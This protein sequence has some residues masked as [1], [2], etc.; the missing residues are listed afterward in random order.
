MADLSLSAGAIHARIEVVAGNTTSR[1]DSVNSGYNRA[2]GGIDPRDPSGEAHVWGFLRPLSTSDALWA[3]TTTEAVAIDATATANLTTTANTFYPSMDQKTIASVTL[4]NEYTMTYVS[5]TSITM[6]ANWTD[7]T[8]DTF[9]IT[10]DGIYPLDDD[11]GGFVDGPVYAYNSS[12]S[13]GP[14]VEADMTEIE[15][16][17]RDDNE[18]GL[19][20]KWAVQPRS[21]TTTGQKYDLVVH[22]VPDSTRAIRYR[23]EVRPTA[24][25]DSTSVYALGT[26]KFHHAIEYAALADWEVLA[27]HTPGVWEGKY[28]EAMAAA[29]DEDSSRY[30][31][32]DVGVNQSDV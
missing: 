5:A 3:T 12:V 27:G 22:P 23:H 30:G 6:S 26:P 31:T 10:P 1:L 18:T 28:Q 8:G 29:I 32:Q 16:L 17:R 20:S 24:L 2:L 13:T 9:T 25:T 14:L 4:S 7:D 15:E 11:F 21:N 19:P